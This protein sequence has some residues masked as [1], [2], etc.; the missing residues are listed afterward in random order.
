MLQA[1][2]GQTLPTRASTPGGDQHAH[3][4]GPRGIGTAVA[5]DWALAVQLLTD[6]VLAALGM[7]PTTGRQVSA[8]ARLPLVAGLLL[9]AV[10]MVVQ[11]E[12][13]RRGRRLAWLLQMAFNALLVLDGLVELPRTVAA[14]QVGHVGQLLRAVV[15]LVVSPLLVWLLSR[16]STRTWVAT[17]T[18]RAAAARH[19]G[20]WIAWIAVC[21]VI[22][23]LAIAFAPY[24]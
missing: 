23:G 8:G 9:A 24:Y 6:A 16:A 3:E 21:A 19:G 15:L 22:G 17:T 20:R 5:F 2:E 1:P 4:H 11:G 12:A 10:L 13:L 14:L 7:L 18:V